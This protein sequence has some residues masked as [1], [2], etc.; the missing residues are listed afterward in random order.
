[1]ISYDQAQLHIEL[2]EK[3]EE[4]ILKEK[5]KEMEKSD[6]RKQEIFVNKL[7]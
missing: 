4:N 3:E 7:Q 1:M 6:M 5:L 2:L